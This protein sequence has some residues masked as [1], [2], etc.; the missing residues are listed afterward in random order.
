MPFVA[1]GAAAVF[2]PGAPGRASGPMSQDHDEAVKPGL[3]S[4]DEAVKPGPQEE[5]SEAT[6]LAKKDRAYW[7]DWSRAQ[8]VYNVVGG[9]L[10]WS[11]CSQV[12]FSTSYHGAPSAEQM[13]NNQTIMM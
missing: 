9:H 4:H 2:P 5:T 12:S 11:V 8:C 3:M 1:P 6:G 13:A 10:F 7:V